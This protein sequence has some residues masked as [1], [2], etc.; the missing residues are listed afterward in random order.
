ML[1]KRIITTL[2]LQEG[3]LFR[4]KQFIPDHRYTLNFI[5][6]WSVDEVVVIDISRDVTFKDK[7]KHYFFEQLLNISKNAYVPI[8]AGGGIRS[9]SD[10]EKLL[11]YGSDK[12]LLNS[13][14][15]NNPKF[16]NEAAKEFGSQCI[17]VSIDILRDNEKYFIMQKY[18]QEK[19]NLDL[20][21]YIKIIQENNAGEIFIQS[22]N[23]DGSLKGYDLNIVDKIQDYVKIPL[24]ISCGAGSW[25][26]VKQALER[27]VIS[28][29]SLTNIFHFTEKSIIN[30]KNFI[31]DEIYI[32]K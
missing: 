22:V 27:E 7:E 10:I 20:I 15:L 5:D 16:I 6:M 30:L 11:K 13:A 2:M 29:A 24:I 18:G 4:S 19:Y 31:K 23:M 28:A 32:R 12:I 26:H 1:A 14:A 9:L 17:V 25:F 8:T 3:V 21:E